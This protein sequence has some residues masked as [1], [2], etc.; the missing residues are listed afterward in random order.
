MSESLDKVFGFPQFVRV[1]WSTASTIIDKKAVTFKWYFFL[2]PLSL[3]PLP[4]EKVL[5]IFR[6]LLNYLPDDNVF[7]LLKLKAF[8]RN[9]TQKFKFVLSRVENNV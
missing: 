1:S 5:H 6:L 7:A 2:S 3:Y 4:D 9:I 8:T